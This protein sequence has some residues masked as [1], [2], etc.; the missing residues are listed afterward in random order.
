MEKFLAIIMA[1]MVGDY[2]FQS[3]YL[4]ANKGKDNYI[5]LAHSVIYTF[6]VML[7]AYLF[8]IETKALNLFLIGA[9]HIPVDYLKARG[10]TVKW[11][12]SSK[13]LLLDQLVHYIT[14]LL[15]I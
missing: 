7:V 11:F 9:I 13:A 12:G 14:L 1:H 3:D 2:L 15:L 10:I 6:G 8:N 5:L 4:A